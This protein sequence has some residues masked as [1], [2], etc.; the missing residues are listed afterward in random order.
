MELSLLYYL[1]RRKPIIGKKR[2]KPCN[3]P[4]TEIFDNTDRW[5]KSLWY[6]DVL[7]AD[8]P[9]CVKPY[10]GEKCALPRDIIKPRPYWQ[11]GIVV[12]DLKCDRA[13]IELYFQ[14]QELKWNSSIQDWECADSY[15]RYVYVHVIIRETD[16]YMCYLELEPKFQYLECT[17]VY[18]IDR[19]Y[20]D[21]TCGGPTF[22]LSVE[23]G[24]PFG[25]WHVIFEYRL[26]DDY[27]FKYWMFVDHPYLSTPKE[28]SDK[29]QYPTDDDRM[30]KMGI[31]ISH[32]YYSEEYSKQELAIDNFTADEP[33]NV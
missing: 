15:S 22:T 25:W 28:Y 20:N 24:P 26:L 14:G 29:F 4:F 2:I 11:Y 33:Q 13:R 23:P 5:E 12:K 31:A 10:V 1:R 19:N 6:S 21:V 16:K 9:K 30:A 27:T 8:V 7:I 18:V 3:Y 32:G 17:G